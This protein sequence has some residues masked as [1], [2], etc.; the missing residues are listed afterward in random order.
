V[1]NISETIGTVDPFC[2]REWLRHR[3]SRTDR[4]RHIIQAAQLKKAQ[5]I[6]CCEVRGN[7]AMDAPYG[8]QLCIWAPSEEKHRNGIV[9]ANI[10]IQEN[11]GALHLWS[12]CR[13][14]ALRVEAFQDFRRSALW[15]IAKCIT[16]SE[17]SLRKRA[18][19][20]LVSRH[21]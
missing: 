14:G 10:C 18:P 12:L 3:A 11:L 1:S 15:S 4:N 9:N 5:R 21:V 16:W 6:C 17:V 7:I 19:P 13:V 8:N 2:G 20:C